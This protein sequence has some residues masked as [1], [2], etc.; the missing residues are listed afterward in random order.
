MILNKIGFE[1]VMELSGSLRLGQKNIYM[2][3][4]SYQTSI[5]KGIPC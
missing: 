2:M 3:L 4:V 1:N 5:K